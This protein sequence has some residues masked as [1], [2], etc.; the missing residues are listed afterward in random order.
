[1]T[2]K[3]EHTLKPIFTAD[4]KILILGTMPSP[5]SRETGFYYGHPQNRMWKVLAGVFGENV[6]Y[7]NEEKAEFLK[8][9]YIAMWDVLAE[10]DIDGAKDSSIKNPVPND[11][12]FIL[13]NSSVKNIFASG[14]T[15]GD[16]YRKYCMESTGAA[17]EVLPSTSPANCTYSLDRL[18]ESYSVIYELCKL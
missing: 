5:K 3:V 7:F 17:A 6:P 2:K 9:H 18:I 1:M 16:L 11:I 10:C 4:S 15:A 12:N 14:K 13:K 8:R